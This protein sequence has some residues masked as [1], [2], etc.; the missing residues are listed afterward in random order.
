MKRRVLF[1]ELRLPGWSR[2][3]QTSWVTGTC[4]ELGW[5]L[6][7]Q[8]GRE[9]VRS[10]QQ[11]LGSKLTSD[12]GKKRKVED[13]QETS[14]PR[15]KVRLL[16]DSDESDCSGKWL[17]YKKMKVALNQVLVWLCPTWSLNPLLQAR[18]QINPRM[19]PELESEDAE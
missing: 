6:L 19:Q 9:R 7:C 18:S 11:R 10:T 17:V 12:S 1:E 4:G 3:K 2:L 15:R 8:F 16:S 14:S 13:S 5:L